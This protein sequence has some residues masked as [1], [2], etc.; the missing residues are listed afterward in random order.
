[1]QSDALM[2]V[3]N[4]G[5][6]GDMTTDRNDTDFQ[7]NFTIETHRKSAQNQDVDVQADES[8]VPLNN[9]HCD[10]TIWVRRSAA[11]TNDGDLRQT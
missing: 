6:I 7:R 2:V 4:R 3:G 5:Q 10:E 1:M 9:A 11:A 8:R